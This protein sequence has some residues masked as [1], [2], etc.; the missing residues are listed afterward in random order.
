MELLGRQFD[1]MGSPDDEIRRIDQ[2]V[3]SWSEPGLGLKIVAV[4]ICED[5][6]D[7][8]KTAALQLDVEYTVHDNQSSLVRL[9]RWH[10]I[11][12]QCLQTTKL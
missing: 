4:Y 1:L 2:N 11:E 9:D 8:M 10:L 7:Y 5:H 3:L 6:L 12:E